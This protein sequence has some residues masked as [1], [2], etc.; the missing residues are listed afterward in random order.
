ME[1][2]DRIQNSLIA[3]KK[4]MIEQLK[5][6]IEQIIAFALYTFQSI[7]KEPVSLP[8]LEILLLD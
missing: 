5:S 3:D 8:V 4:A 1:V 7:K 6:S 2:A